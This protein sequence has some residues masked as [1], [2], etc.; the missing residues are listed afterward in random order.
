MRNRL[1][2]LIWRER[3]ARF[4]WGGLLLVALAAAVAVFL[5]DMPLPAGTVEGRFLRVQGA[6]TRYGTWPLWHV[7]TPGGAV[8]TLRA[9]AGP[10]PEPGAAV[11]LRIQRSRLLGRTTARYL[12]AGACP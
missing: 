2:W 5:A 1:R 9:P 8:A 12:K 3:L 6:Q 10:V 11:C 4:G 7:E